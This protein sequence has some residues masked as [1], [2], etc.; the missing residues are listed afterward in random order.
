M[1]QVPPQRSQGY[2]LIELLVVLVLVSIITALAV[3]SMTGVLQSHH[4]RTT[5]DQLAGDIHFARL[6]AMRSGAR[7]EIAF[8]WDSRRRCI[9]H[10]EVREVD[11]GVAL[12]SV[13]VAS[14]LVG[15]CLSMNNAR[16]PLVF[17]SRGLPFGVM[18]RRIVAESGRSADTLVMS[19][20][21]RIL[22]QY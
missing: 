20:L 4:S 8:S 11:G 12:R 18:A 3:P 21:G 2:S 1:P 9:L 14:G 22:R 17:N 7:V 6:Q 13:D 16:Q 15:G 19:Q 5:L 10:Y